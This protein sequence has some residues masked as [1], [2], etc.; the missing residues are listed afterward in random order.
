[1]CIGLRSNQMN[2]L[3]SLGSFYEKMKLDLP[4]VKEFL[5]RKIRLLMKEMQISL[6]RKIIDGLTAW[7]N[8]EEYL[9]NGECGEA[10]KIYELISINSGAQLKQKGCKASE[11][12]WEVQKR[13]RDLRKLRIFRG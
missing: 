9:V 12:R 2:Q 3:N 6:L 4:E 7:E 1:M 5:K 11:N 10:E 13:L 8:G